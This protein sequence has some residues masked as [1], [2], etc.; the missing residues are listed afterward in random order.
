M[1]TRSQNKS[2]QNINQQTPTRYSR[3]IAGLPPL[4]FQ[5]NSDSD[6]R[7]IDED[8]LSTE[9]NNYIEEKMNQEIDIT[10]TIDERDLGELCMICL[11]PIKSLDQYTIPC[12]HYICNVCAVEWMKIKIICPICNK[13]LIPDDIFERSNMKIIPPG[14]WLCEFIKNLFFDD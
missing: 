12:E 10:M 14:L 9:I 2:N 5:N 3:R 13:I 1:I 7:L 8:H 11:E 6:I 4:P